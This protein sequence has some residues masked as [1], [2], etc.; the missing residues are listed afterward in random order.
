M[1]LVTELIWSN[2]LLDELGFQHP[3]PMVLKCDNQV[4]SYIANNQVFHETTK[5]IVIGYHF[6][7][8]GFERNDSNTNEIK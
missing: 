3:Q 8:E 2:Y 5:H 7:R 1:V 4:V 6:V